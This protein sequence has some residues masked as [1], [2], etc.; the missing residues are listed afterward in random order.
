MLYHYYSV[1]IAFPVMSFT[2]FELLPIK[3]VLNYGKT[4]AIVK[5]RTVPH[6]TYCSRL[7]WLHIEWLGQF[8]PRSMLCVSTSIRA[9]LCKGLSY[10]RIL[11]VLIKPEIYIWLWNIHHF[12]VMVKHNFRFHQITHTALSNLCLEQKIFQ[13]RG[14]QCIRFNSNTSCEMWALTPIN[15]HINN[16][17]LVF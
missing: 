17:W 10:G 9:Q 11:H 13:I 2:R 3:S 16:I 8:R 14:Q 5:K 12:C 6:S 15:S 7:L 4:F 1:C